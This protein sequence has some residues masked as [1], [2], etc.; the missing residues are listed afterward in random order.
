MAT[1][2]SDIFDLFLTRVDDYRITTLYQTSGSAGLNTYLEPWLLDSIVDFD[3]CNQPLNYTTISGSAEGFFADDLSLENRIIL[4]EIMTVHW[5][6]KTVQNILN[7]SLIIQDHDMKTY[8]Q[9]QN[10]KEKKDYLSMKREQVSQ[11]L[12]NYSYKYND[13]T[14]WRNQS[15]A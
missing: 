11:L 14:S 9:A 2:C 15:F 8:S 10:L 12:Q 5:M 3:I 13:W 6:E 4:S 7:M 1:T